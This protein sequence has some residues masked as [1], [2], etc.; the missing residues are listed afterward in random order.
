MI[1]FTFIISFKKHLDIGVFYVIMIHNK[2]FKGD[3]MDFKKYSSI[4]NTYREKVIDEI[5]IQDIDKTDWVVSEK[6][7]GANFSFWMNVEGLRCARRTSF[8]TNKDNFYQYQ[9]LTELYS[10]HLS[11]LYQMCVMM[12]EDMKKDKLIDFDSN[13]IEVVLYGEL[14]GGSYHHPD[15]KRDDYAQ[16]VQKGVQYCPWNDFYAFDL[17]INGSI[18]HYDIFSE[19]MEN[20]GFHYAKALYRGSFD[21][22]LKCDNSIPTTIPK[23]LGLPEIEYNIA[24]GLVLKP[25]QYQC[26]HDGSRVIL[27]N[28]NEKFK[29]IQSEKKIKVNAQLT[30]VEKHFI[31]LA[32]KYITENRLTNVISH[33]GEITNKDFGKIL[34]AFCK[35]INEEVEKECKDLKEYLQLEKCN[36]KAINKVINKNAQPMV[37]ERFLNIIS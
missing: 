20:V 21:D 33:L 37:K 8:L 19:L 15:V 32:G 18:V 22:C 24:E 30:D 3:I 29:E 23:H 16:R 25:A 31:D 27:K 5:R 11:L 10:Q 35:D 2:L 28:K 34:G 12:M 14:F 26:F 36:I 9:N 4:E 17:S 13:S 1:Q 7:H 6:I